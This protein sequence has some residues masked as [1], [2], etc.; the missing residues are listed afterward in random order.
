MAAGR[1]A[2]PRRPP[3]A[4]RTRRGLWVTV[5]LGLVGVFLA[6]R[7][8]YERLLPAALAA[9]RGATGAEVAASDLGLGLG[10]GGPHL[11]ARD[12]RV[13]WPGTPELVFD[14]VRVRPAWSPSWLAGRPAWHLAAEGAAGRWQGVLAVDRLAGAWRDVDSD[15]L[16]WVLLGSLAPVHGRV[17]GEVDLARSDGAWRGSAQ[18]SG[19]EGSVDLPG[20]PVAIP[21]VALEAALDV[22]P[23]QL[24][25]AS[26]RLEGP[27][28]TARAGGTLGA[29]AG[30]LS[31]WPIDLQVEIESIDP[32][33]RGYLGPL[34]IPVSADGRAQLRVGGTLAAPFLSGAPP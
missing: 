23:E 18:L 10:L 31:A 4:G 28:V 9:A 24:T 16:P 20:L 21:F 32:A 30:A 5:V 8:P 3:R 17:S 11:R 22:A 13:R 2:V 12:V 33:L 14:S 19:A 15:A 7:F 34:G 25:L 27:L 1:A 29:A 6:A 26:G